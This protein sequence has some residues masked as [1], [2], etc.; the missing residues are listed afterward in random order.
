MATITGSGGGGGMEGR[1]SRRHLARPAAVHASSSGHWSV[2]PVF[3][4]MWA[5]LA[6][7]YR[8]WAAAETRGPPLG[9]RRWAVRCR[10]V[11]GGRSRDRRARQ[12]TRGHRRDWAGHADS[13]QAARSR[14]GLG[15]VM[16]YGQSG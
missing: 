1:S 14:S 16:P 3:G 9:R 7:N 11:A 8:R 12:L 10:E 2:S 4:R 13:R 15:M 6:S 5:P